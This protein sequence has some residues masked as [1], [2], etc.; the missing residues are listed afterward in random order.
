METRSHQPKK[1]QRLRSSVPV[2]AGRS[3]AV[4]H[5]D[6]QARKCIVRLY[7]KVK[8]L[9]SARGPKERALEKA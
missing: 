6:A 2:R 5:D 1:Y 8:L 4:A 3:E 9:S 7:S